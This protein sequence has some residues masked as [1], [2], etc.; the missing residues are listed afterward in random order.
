[1]NGYHCTS[2]RVQQTAGRLIDS[3]CIIALRRSLTTLIAPFLSLGP[4]PNLFT[5]SSIRRLFV[6]GRLS[7]DGRSRVFRF[8]CCPG[9]TPTP[10]DSSTRYYVEQQRVFMSNLV[11]FVS[12]CV[13]YDIIM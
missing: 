7:D 3:K 8:F 12:V 5:G 13:V 4:F 9:T 11:P 10:P 1:M 6:V 2:W